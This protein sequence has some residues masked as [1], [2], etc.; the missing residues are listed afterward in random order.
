M[1][2]GS[3]MLN[4]VG[5]QHDMNMCLKGK[6]RNNLCTTSKTRH[7]LRMTSKTRYTYNLEHVIFKHGM[8]Y[9]IEHI[10]KFSICSMA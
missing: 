9:G 4:S 10:N 1:Y 5:R 7:D 8:A 3:V 2:I 6:A